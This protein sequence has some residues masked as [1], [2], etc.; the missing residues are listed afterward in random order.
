MRLNGD[1]LPGYSPLDD[2]KLS[3]LYN[4]GA[5]YPEP[6][7]TYGVGRPDGWIYD[8]HHLLDYSLHCNILC[9]DGDRL[10]SHPPLDDI[11]LFRLYNCG[12]GYPEP[13]FTYD[14]D[15]CGRWIYNQH[16]LLDHSLYCN[17]VC[18]NSD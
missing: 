12:S 11:K 3:R 13:S 18:L 4:C 1:R 10:S 17:I 9:P 7:F 16:H 6:F 8:Q 14:V 2:I 15:K 5:R